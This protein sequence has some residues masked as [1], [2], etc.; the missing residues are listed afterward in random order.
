[1]IHPCFKS[2][3]RHPSQEFFKSLSVFAQVLQSQNFDHSVNACHEDLFYSPDTTHFAITKTLVNCYT[4]KQSW[5]LCWVRFWTM[6]FPSNSFRTWKYVTLL[7]NDNCLLSTCAVIAGTAQL[8]HMLLK[9]VDTIFECK[10]C[11]SLFRGLP[12]LVTHKE[13]YCFSR[14]P[15]SDGLY[16]HLSALTFKVF[17]SLYDFILFCRIQKEYILKNASTVQSQLEF[18]HIALHWLSLY[19]QNIIFK[20]FSFCAPQKEEM[21]KHS[22]NYIAMS[23]KPLG[24][25][26]I[27]LHGQAPFMCSSKDVK[28]YFKLLHLGPWI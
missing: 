11:R 10:I 7:T 22:S 14:Q 18:K 8:K 19:G 15:Q 13:L 26:L 12:N 9:E 3:S 24:N 16:I 25:S 23:K 5:N 2:S 28:M 17:Q 20:I 1:M 27:E 4:T 6:R 21:W